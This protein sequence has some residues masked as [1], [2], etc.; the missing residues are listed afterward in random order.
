MCAGI[1]AI[2]EQQK[3]HKE[4]IHGGLNGDLLIGTALVDLYAN[5]GRLSEARKVFDKMTLR[6]IV[7]WN[8]L[9][10]G[11]V[12]QE[13]NQQAMECLEGMKLQEI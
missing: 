13:S 3:L 1:G 8:A 7:V 5:F 11:Y 6:N 9:I 10:A 2:K 12:E 4:V